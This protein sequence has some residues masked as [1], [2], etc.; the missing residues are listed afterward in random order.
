MPGPTFRGFVVGGL[1][2]VILH[3]IVRFILGNLV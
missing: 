1:I 3:L 2:G